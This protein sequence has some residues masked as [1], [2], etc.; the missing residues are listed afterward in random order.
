[1]SRLIHYCVLFLFLFFIIPTPSYA[2]RYAECD[3]CGYCNG[4]EAPESWESCRACLYPS[5]SG[6][7]SDNNTLEII[8][9]P[10]DPRLDPAKKALNK[11]IPPAKGKYYTQLGCVD[12]SLSSFSDPGA[13][14]GVLNFILTKLIFPATGVLA[15]GTLIYGSFIL[16]T[17]QGAQMQIA[18]GRRYVIG[19]IVG[20]IFTF[21]VALIINIIGNDVLRIPGFG[22][23]T[24]ITF[25]GYGT[26]TTEGSVETFPNILVQFDGQD[27]NTI[28][29]VTGSASNP[30]EYTVILPKKI[31]VNNQA[32]INKV[33]FLFNNDK[34]FNC[35]T[36]DATHFGD[37][38]IYNTR[39]LFDD[40]PCAQRVLMRETNPRYKGPFADKQLLQNNWPDKPIIC[41]QL[42]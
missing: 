10:N 15:F 21:S 33:T 7:P 34:C 19:S 40:I 4:K 20:L 32:E 9:D 22:Q 41:T 17:A 35:Q 38:N 26:S 28:K 6:V 18:R 13:V 5:V 25:V 42:Q 36:P 11:P 37:R 16:I 12:T 29:G 24:K 8:T 23:G 2:A 3:A 39:I 27:V 1:M 30:Q 31:N 14:G